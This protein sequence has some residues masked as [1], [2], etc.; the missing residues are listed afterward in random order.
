VSAGGGGEPNIVLLRFKSRM[1]GALDPRNEVWPDGLPGTP[2]SRFVPLF[3][4]RPGLR[5]LLVV[6]DADVLERLVAP[7][8]DE[9]DSFARVAGS[10]QVHQSVAVRRPGAACRGDRQGDLQLAGGTV[11]LARAVP[12]RKR[13]QQVVCRGTSVRARKDGPFF[14]S[15]AWRLQK[16]RSAS[17]RGP[18]RE[19]PGGL[20]RSSQAHRDAFPEAPRGPW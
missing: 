6:I 8:A 17:R 14:S 20:A 15:T 13:W 7:K 19:A 9:A 10:P 2:D 5:K 12:S 18:S 11:R 3:V 4:P 16:G 1:P